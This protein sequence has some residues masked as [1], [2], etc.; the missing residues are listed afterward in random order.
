ME[1]YRPQ[2][3]KRVLQLLGGGKGKAK[4]IAG[5]TNVIPD[6]RGKTIQPDALIDLSH[7]KSLSYIKEGNKSIRLGALT[8]IAQMASSKV[9]KNYAPI[10][11]EAAQQLGNPLV[12]NR[13]TIGGNL[14]DASPAA[15]T[16]PPL[17]ALDA[18]IITENATNNKKAIPIDQF[19][20]GPNQ[21]VLK[22]DEMIK[23]IIVP[24][25]TSPHI[26][27]AY[28]KLGLRNSMSISVISMALWIDVEE[29]F[30][31]QIRI[32][33]G[34]VAPTPIRA[35]KTEEMVTG[36]EITPDLIEACGSELKKEV[37]P[38]TDI[39]ASAEY[40]REMASVLF[41]RLIERVTFEQRE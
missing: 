1:Y 18:R 26:K 3:L 31:K 7:L 32:G 28:I 17:L 34:A 15:D 27:T 25:W 16:A 19:F 33:L 23:E 6:L 10:L 39:R 38:I 37:R 14:S 30:C 12:R 36:K 8:T 9:I 24:K 21:T 41:K 4:L 35:L 13:A 5:G 11:S 29:M 40:R 20:K 2:H 22:R